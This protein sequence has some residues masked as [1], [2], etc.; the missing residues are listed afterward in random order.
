[1]ALSVCLS[2]SLSVCLSVC[3][4]VSLYVT[5]SQTTP[6]GVGGGSVLQEQ[7]IRCFF[8]FFGF[9]QAEAAVV[10][11][12]YIHTFVRFNLLSRMLVA[13]TFLENNKS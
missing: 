2:V 5:V 7:Q 3:L 1:M 12:H 8:G 11:K 13:D 4:S 10:L 6:E 9:P